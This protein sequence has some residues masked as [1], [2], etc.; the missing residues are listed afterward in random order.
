[1]A[2]AYQPQKAMGNNE[3]CFHVKNIRRHIISSF[4]Y[5]TDMH[6]EIDVYF[7]CA[8]WVLGDIVLV[9]ALLAKSAILLNEK[10]IA[11]V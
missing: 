9:G 8:S 4:P 1:M 6:R 11:E 3:G 5:A 2:T 10:N 7:A